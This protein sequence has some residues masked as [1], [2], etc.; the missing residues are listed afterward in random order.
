MTLAQDW[1]ARWA[2]YSPD[3]VAVKEHE[4][5]RTLTYLQLDRLGNRLAHHLTAEYGIDKGDRVAVLAENCL[6]YI[7]LFAA[8]QKT[9]LILVPLNYRLAAAEIDYLLANSQ[10]KLVIGEGKFQA[11][12]DG[13][14]TYQE[15]PHRWTIEGVASLIDPSQKKKVDEHFAGRPVEEDHPIF[16]LYTS[17]TTGFPKGA[18][19]THKMLFWNSINTAMSLLVNTES[20]TVNCM[21]PFHTGGWNVLTTPFLHH[22]GYVCLLKKFDPE[23]VLSLL[24]KEQVTVFMG[25]PTMLKMIADVPAFEQ[26]DFSSLYYLI[27]GGEPMPVPLIEQWDAKGVP[28]RQGF[29]MT[30]VGPNLFSLHQRDALRKKGSIGRPNFYVLIRIVDP[31]GKEVPVDQPGELLLKGPMVTPGYWRNEVATAKTIVDGWFHSGDML[32]QDAEGYLFVVD[33]IKNMYISGGENVYP[34]EIERVLVAHPAISEV[35]VIGVPDE[36]WGEVGKAFVVKNGELTEEEVLAYC[37]QQLARFKV[38]KTI[39]FIESLPKND[40]GK[41]DRRALK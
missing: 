4:T 27:V 36:K 41:I 32:R 35:A 25:V 38:P 18:L 13:A 15:V 17:G 3:K 21:P 8:A 19:Y 22:G 1:S 40:T 7:V 2:L 16:I 37:R 23:V 29:G 20:R 34:A 28:V 10:P 26:A 24:E 31:E 9:G 39:A 14:P 12:L 6:E 33:R 5:Q 11:Q 30:E